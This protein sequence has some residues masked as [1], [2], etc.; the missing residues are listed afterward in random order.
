MQ[1]GFLSTIFCF[2]AQSLSLHS[3]VIIPAGELD[4]LQDST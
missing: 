1:F 2:Q 3:Q 4:V